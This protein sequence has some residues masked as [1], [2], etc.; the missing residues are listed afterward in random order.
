[1]PG[2]V[3]STYA[4]SVTVQ[5]SDGSA[6]DLTGADLGMRFFQPSPSRNSST[7]LTEGSGL[8][9]TDPSSGIFTLNLTPSQTKDLGAGSIRVELFKNYSN[10]T[11]RVMLA[12]GTEVFE[13]GRFDG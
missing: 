12:E 7:D 2:Y 9:V 8:T 10:D 4:V 6:Y 11:T 1:M 3:N 5:N 13:G